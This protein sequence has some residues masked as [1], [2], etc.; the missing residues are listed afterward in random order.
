MS[1]LEQQLPDIIKSLSSTYG[2]AFFNELTL[3]LNKFIDADY[4]FIARFDS[5][6]NTSKTISLV[7]KGELI[8]N[9]EYSLDETPCADVSLM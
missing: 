1:T 2:S 4:T 8:D 5:V 6:K 3:Q 7:A 9:F